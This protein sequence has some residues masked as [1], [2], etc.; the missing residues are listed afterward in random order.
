MK[1]ALLILALTATAARTASG[2]GAATA[3]RKQF[4]PRPATPVCAA[5]GASIIEIEVV[6]DPMGGQQGHSTTTAVYANGA[7]TRLR[8]EDRQRAS[9]APRTGCLEK[10][11]LDALQADLK[12][13]TWKITHN[14]ITCRAIS[15]RHVIYRI[16]GKQK[17]DSHVCGADVVDDATSK[18]LED[19]T[20]QLSGL[21]DVEPKST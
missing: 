8:R 4:A 1:I 15:A 10:A 20:K 7:W 16:A 6:F 2:D 18:A 12:A 11:Q 9:A 5:T 21:P 19:I 17:W 3:E 13:A 14:R